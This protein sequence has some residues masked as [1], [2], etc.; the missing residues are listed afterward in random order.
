MEIITLILSLYSWS[1]I[2]VLLL[3]LW[4]IA[5]F[6]EKT[7]GQYV[8]RRFLLVP[9]SFLIAGA[10]WYLWHSVKFIGKPIGDFLLSTG[11]FLLYVFGSRLQ[12]SMTG[13]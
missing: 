9:A 10:I 12:E 1:V 6:Y 2:G 3:F 4:R 11:G 8:G 13:R 7:S 5:Y